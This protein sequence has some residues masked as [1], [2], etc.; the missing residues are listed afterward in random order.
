MIMQLI[1][2]VNEIRTE[3]NYVELSRLT[4]GE[5]IFKACIL[6]GMCLAQGGGSFSVFCPSVF[7]FLCNVDPLS[8]DPTIQEVPDQNTRELLTKVGTCCAISERRL[9]II[10]P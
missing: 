1:R 7:K 2:S 3:Y 8:L 5:C 10:F 9:L 4:I 6:S